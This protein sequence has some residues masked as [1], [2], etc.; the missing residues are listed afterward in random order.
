V[1]EHRKRE[2]CATMADE[3]PHPDEASTL[4][5]QAEE[6]RDRVLNASL[7]LICIAGMDG[8]PS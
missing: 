6:D 7:D 5:R 8:S 1:A 3:Q 2:R 4:R